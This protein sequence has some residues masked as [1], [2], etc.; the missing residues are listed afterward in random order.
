[1]VSS[2][3]SVT[4][5]GYWGSFQGHQDAQIKE[6]PF[7]VSKANNVLSV[8]YLM[9]M[10][11]ISLLSSHISVIIGIFINSGPFLVRFF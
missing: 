9:Y 6:N 3:A 8:I 10:P 2:L 5:E 7:V 1:M 4:A 11:P